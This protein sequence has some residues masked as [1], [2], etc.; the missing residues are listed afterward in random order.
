MVGVFGVWPRQLE[1]DVRPRDG[2]PGEGHYHLHL[3]SA[4]QHEFVRAR[5]VALLGVQVANLDGELV[6]TLLQIEYYPRSPEQ[7]MFTSKLT[8]T[9]ALSCLVT[10]ST[11]VSRTQSNSR[12]RDATSSA[13]TAPIAQ[14]RVPIPGTETNLMERRQKL[15]H[16]E[17]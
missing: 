16:R 3:I 6:G 11:S 15:K 9:A 13:V 10:L 8:V 1:V 2:V 7:Q 4:G 14:I 12:C 5:V 17:M